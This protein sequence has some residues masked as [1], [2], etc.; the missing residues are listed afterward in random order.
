MIITLPPFQA[1]TS[2]RRLGQSRSVNVEDILIGFI[3]TIG[4][5]WSSPGVRLTCGF[6]AL[7]FSFIV[8]FFIASL[9][10]GGGSQGGQ[11]PPPPPPPPS[12]QVP[13]VLWPGDAFVSTTVGD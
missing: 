1:Q 3:Q 12:P 2:D 8:L 11:T 10:C 9:G 6:R 4:T 5:A 7:C 13:T